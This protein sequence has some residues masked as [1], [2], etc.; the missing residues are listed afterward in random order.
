MTA[1]VAHEGSFRLGPTHR[2]MVTV[3][4]GGVKA[5]S[6]EIEALH[7][8]RVHLWELFFA[9]RSSTSSPDCSTRKDSLSGSTSGC[10]VRLCPQ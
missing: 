5:G 10:W 8:G 9:E 3:A 4:G 6:S 1:V 7:L 2:V